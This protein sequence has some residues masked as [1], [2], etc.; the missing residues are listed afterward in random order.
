MAT[1]TRPGGRRLQEKMRPYYEQ[2]R[3][4]M[5][6]D[7]PEWFFN[8][9]LGCPTYVPGSGKPGLYPKQIETSNSVRDNR[10]TAE[11]G[12]NGTG[13]DYKSGRL[14]LWWMYA[15]DD[16]MVIVYGPTSRQ[17]NEIIWKEGRVA[18]HGSN[19]PLPGRMYTGA[20][21]YVIGD[22]REAQGFS[23]DS[24]AT[25]AG[26]QGFHSGHLLVIVTE[27]HGVTQPE[28]DALLRLNPN[29]MLLTGNPLSTGGEFYDAFHSKREIYNT[30]TISAFDT[31]NVIERKDIIPGMVT[32]EDV[33]DRAIEFGE[34]SSYYRQAIL[35]EFPEDAEDA[36]IPLSKANAAVA[37]D[38]TRV[39]PCVLPSE[40]AILGVDVARGGGGDNS[41]IAYRWGPIV[42]IL[43][44]SKTTDPMGLAGQVQLALDEH[45]E[46]ET[47]VV[48]DTGVGGGTTA[49]LEE[50]DIDASVV[51]FIA[52]GKADAPEKF[53]NATAEAWWHMRLAFMGGDVDTEADEA[54]IAQVTTRM[55]RVQSDK[56]IR[57]ESKDEMKKRL[58]HSPDEADAVAMTYSP[59]VGPPRIR[60]FG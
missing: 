2:A 5:A 33:Q 60:W 6:R 30:I 51:A 13:K 43:F 42:R 24:S 8:V 9:I 41:I 46:V 49:R 54:F 18:F 16:A 23:S 57:L 36:L 27:A 15:Y 14:M 22:F 39:P 21:K 25:G 37:R 29:R 4:L 12:A 48:D 56:T 50:L 40:S 32:L 34:D 10:R 11:V 59:A 47:V 26:I 31:P 35:G 45:P 3:Q 44:K 1:K 19:V 53:Y 20:S 7:D 17:V 28:I 52:G 55:Y 38:L 58:R